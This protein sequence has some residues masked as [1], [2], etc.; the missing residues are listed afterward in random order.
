MPNCDKLLDRARSSQANFRFKDLCS[1]AE[2]HGFV[3]DHIRGGHHIYKRPGWPKVMNFQNRK[4]K[5]QRYQV[6][7]LLNAIDLILAGIVPSE[8]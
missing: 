7:G 2:C 1:L 3:F 8:E 5:A 4:G 6:R